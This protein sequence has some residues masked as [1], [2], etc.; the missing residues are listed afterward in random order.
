MRHAHSAPTEVTRVQ[1]LFS[2]YKE[3]QHFK[4]IFKIQL[5]EYGGSW[6]DWEESP[7]PPPLMYSIPQDLSEHKLRGK[8]ED[9]ALGT[10]LHINLTV[11]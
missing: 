3:Y 10:G 8:L 6:S 1:L 7:P 9:S 11:P 5:A 2:E 4:L